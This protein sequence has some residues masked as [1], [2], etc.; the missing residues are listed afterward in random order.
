[1]SKLKSR[2][3][4]DALRRHRLNWEAAIEDAKEQICQ[5]QRRVA[6]LKAAIL[7]SKRGE[8]G[9]YHFQD[10]TRVRTLP[11]AGTA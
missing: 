10:T 8:E 9:M 4:L 5:A 11:G 7:V 2:K 6:H 1:M 3:K